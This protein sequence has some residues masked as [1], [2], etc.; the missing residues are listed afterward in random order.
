MYMKFTNSFLGRQYHTASKL[1]FENDTQQLKYISTY[2]EP[3]YPLPSL[4]ATTKN[5]QK[6]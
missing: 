3:P 1:L 2:P 4:K 5:L 6:I